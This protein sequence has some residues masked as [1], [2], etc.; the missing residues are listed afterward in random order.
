M[1]MC[2]SCKTSKSSDNFWKDK[3]NP[4]DG[5]QNRCK[6]C[7]KYDRILRVYNLTVEQYDNMQMKQD[8]SCAI[9]HIPS[10]SLR[11]D[12]DH[13]CCPGEQS[14]GK[15]VRALLCH[16]CNCTL[17]YGKDNPELLR[18]AADYIESHRKEID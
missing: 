2:G 7:Q 15:C 6:R 13:S 12:H 1:K 11:V 18:K 5:L 9:C 14:C 4:R 10:E 17:G 8:Y 16:N 3:S